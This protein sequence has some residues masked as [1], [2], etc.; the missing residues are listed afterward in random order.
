MS[1]AVATPQAAAGAGEAAP[2]KRRPGKKILVV[3]VV[4]LAA[5]GAGYWFFLKPGPTGPQPG[6][7]TPLDSI[8]VNLADGHY[9]RLGLALQLTKG[10]K[11]V[12]GSKALDA[13]IDLFSGE[14]VAQVDKR[15]VREKLR[16]R[17]DHT[18]EDRYDGEV[19]DVYF[20]EFVT[21]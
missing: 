19:M 8:Q 10:T 5:G 1:T 15:S 21:Q 17:L 3:L 16:T 18:L 2:A 11:E 7:V 13:A 6:D 12:D 20:T 14:P 9:L 4:L